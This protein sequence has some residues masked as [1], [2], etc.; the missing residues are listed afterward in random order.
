MTTISFDP[1]IM[2]CK[3]QTGSFIGS[4][5][6]CTENE[7]EKSAMLVLFEIML[8]YKPPEPSAPKIVIDPSKPWFSQPRSYLQTLATKYNKKLVVDVST[9]P[10]KLTVIMTFDS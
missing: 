6:G 2:E 1:A 5:L 9:I 7:A 3:F 8:T 4:G 10:I